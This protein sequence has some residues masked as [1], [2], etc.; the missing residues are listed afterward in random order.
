VFGGVRDLQAGLELMTGFI[1]HVQLGTTLH[2]PLYDTLCLL[3]HLPCRLKRLAQLFFQ[4]K[5]K[6]LYDCRFTANR[7]V[8]A[9]GPM[10]HTTRDF[11]FFNRA[12]KVIVLM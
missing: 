3:H 10:K 5:S 2:K 7:F 4:S 8:L 9:P 12:L 11:F 6:F 1:G